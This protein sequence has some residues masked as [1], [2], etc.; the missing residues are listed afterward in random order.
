[1]A[2]PAVPGRRSIGMLLFGALFAV[3]ALAFFALNVVPA[4]WL[5]R[6]SKDWTPVPAQ[7]LEAGLDRSYGDDGTTYRATARFAYTFNGAAYTGGR[8]GWTSASDNISDW[9]ERMYR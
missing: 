4:V 8:V 7:V 6:V 5:H 1:M 3:A 9:H 2:P